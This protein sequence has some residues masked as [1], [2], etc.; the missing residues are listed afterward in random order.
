MQRTAQMIEAGNKARC[1]LTG[2]TVNLEAGALREA[3]NL[4]IARL[5]PGTCAASPGGPAPAGKSCS[6]EEPAWH[7][8]YG[9]ERLAHQACLVM[10]ALTAGLQAAACKDRPRD[11]IGKCCDRAYRWCCC[12]LHARDPCCSASR[13]NAAVAPC[14]QRETTCAQA[15]RIQRTYQSFAATPRPLQDSA[16][17]LACHGAVQVECAAAGNTITV[18]GHLTAP[19]CKET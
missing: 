16:L 2:R 19:V 17:A 8:A 5:S 12:G 18:V 3:G 15:K 4:S 14:F 13:V 7:H 11:R 9:G 6:S 10:W 1:E